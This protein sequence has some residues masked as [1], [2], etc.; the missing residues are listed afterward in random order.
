M[1]QRLT[2]RQIEVSIG[3]REI[4]KIPDGDSWGPFTDVM[5]A[6][7]Q[8]IEGTESLVNP[9]EMQKRFSRAWEL[10]AK[11][12]AGEHNR[13]VRDCLGGSQREFE[14]VRSH[15][16]GKAAIGRILTRV[17]E[18]HGELTPG[19]EIDVNVGDILDDLELGEHG[20]T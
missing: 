8:M 7:S 10:Y 9:G 4:V 3:V 5:R 20:E 15:P 11:M 17:R 18:V 2:D 14:R 16:N 13:I 19:M 1:R 12:W 6:M